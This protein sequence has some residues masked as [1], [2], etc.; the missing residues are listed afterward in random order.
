MAPRKK[1]KKSP[2]LI[3]EAAKAGLIS[4]G[5]RGLGLAFAAVSVVVLVA[6]ISFNAEDPTL[7]RV[8]DSPA[9]NL[10][11][12]P[13]SYLADLLLQTVGLG[14]VGIIVSFLGWGWRIGSLRGL[15]KPWVNLLAFPFLVM[16]LSVAAGAFGVGESWPVAAGFGGILGAALTGFVD[17]A[18]FAIFEIYP[19]AWA[20]ALL[21][22]G[23]AT[24]L[25]R[26]TLGLENEE[27]LY[28]VAKSRDG[29]KILG[30]IPRGI[31]DL[32]FRR[33]E[34]EPREILVRKP[35]RAAKSPGVEKPSRKARRSKAKIAGPAKTK[36][37][38]RASRERQPSLNLGEAK[39]FELPTLD[40]LAEPEHPA[41]RARISK[42]SL[43]QNARLLE[44]VLDDF[45][46]QG[47]IVNVRPGPVVTLYELEPAPG[48]KSSRVISLADDIAR[49]MSAVSARVAVIDPPSK[50]AREILESRSF[51]HP[52]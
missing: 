24:V 21:F 39:A 38:K 16:A 23:F 29:A 8:T 14:A 22:I 45:G 31:F 18:F 44:S 17:R 41:G 50:L 47:A 12:W 1:S 52:D 35:K 19:P 2:P 9:A 51:I 20:V 4:L 42:E 43:E 10:L 25:A 11:G 49:S 32:A 5:W 36:T 34:R 40:L 30:R 46:I 48:T 26:F 33:G 28:L 3:P 27:W 15:E 6:L 13:G 7:N 37:G